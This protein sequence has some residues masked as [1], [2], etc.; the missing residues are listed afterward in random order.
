[1]VV[2]VPLLRFCQEHAEVV[3]RSLHAL[4]LAFFCAL[5]DECCAYHTVACCHVEVQLF[6]FFGYRQDRWGRECLLQ[7]RECFAGFFGPLE[8]LSFPE[9][10]V[11]WQ[12]AF[13][14]SA[15]ETTQGCES[16]SELLH[17]FDVGWLLHPGDCLNFLWVRFDSS[18]GNHVPE[19]LPGWYAEC[20]LLRVELD[21]I[22]VECCEGLAQVVE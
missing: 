18:G 12:R 13:P 4:A 22:L 2:R 17:T 19:Q 21:S 16:S 6:S 11:E 8:F 1:M 10:L 9:Q 20:A 3:D 5:D 15:D 7:V 14:Q